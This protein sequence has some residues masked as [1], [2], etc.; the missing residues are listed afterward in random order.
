MRTWKLLPGNEPAPFVA[1]PSPDAAGTDLV[2]PVG[3][4]GGDDEQQIY[5]TYLSAIR[6]AHERIWLTHAYFSP[7]SHLLGALKDAARRGLWQ[8]LMENVASGFNYWL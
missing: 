5:S 1:Y 7:D 4:S 2:R 8:R 6:N 3:S